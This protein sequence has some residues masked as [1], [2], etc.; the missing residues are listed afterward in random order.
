VAKATGLDK[1]QAVAIVEGFLEEFERWFD[2]PNGPVLSDIEKVL[3]KN[4]KMR[5]NGEL[6]IRSSEDYLKR[7][8]LLRQRYAGVRISHVLGDTPVWNHSAVVQYTVTFTGH[9][10]KETELYFMGVVTVEDGK[11]RDWMQVTHQKGIRWDTAE[12]Q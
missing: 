10:G 2:L 3:S 6:L 9:N 4:V 7:V 12:E 11:I 8:N 1:A 5:S